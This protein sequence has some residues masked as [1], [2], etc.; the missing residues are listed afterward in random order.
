MHELIVHQKLHIS[1]HLNLPE[2]KN[3]TPE[4]SSLLSWYY[5][6]REIT[7]SMTAFGFTTWFESEGVNLLGLR[8]E[9]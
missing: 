4:V 6:F 1:L 9:E 7:D 5:L 3:K 2:C 8:E